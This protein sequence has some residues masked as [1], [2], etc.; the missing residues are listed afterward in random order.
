MPTKNFENLH[1]YNKFT[2]INISQTKLKTEPKKY[3]SE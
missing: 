2:T 1:I 3:I